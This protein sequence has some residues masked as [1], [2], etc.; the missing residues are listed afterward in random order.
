M[1]ARPPLPQGTAAIPLILP[2]LNALR[3]FEAAA[4]TGSHVAAA[5]ELGISAAAVSQHIRKLEDWLG[6]Q[7]FTRL[8]NRILLT[9]AGR[10]VFEGAAAGL[11]LI[12]DTAEA[13]RVR[14]SHARLVISC[15]E[16]VADKWLVPRLAAYAAAH[17]G[18]RFDLRIEPDPADFACHGIDLRLGYDPAHYPD[19][20]MALLVRDVV[21]PLCSPAY[22]DRNPAA[23]AQGMAAVPDEDLLHTDWGPAFGSHPGWRGWHDRAGLP[24]PVAARGFQI[25]NSAAALDLAR[26]GLG[27]VLGQRMVA[28]AD[29]AA[30]RLLAL[31]DL[32]LP[33]GRAYCLVWPQARRNRRHLAGLVD[34]LRQDAPP[35]A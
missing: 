3:A 4:R 23:G 19:K 33:L 1:L 32:S 11:Q 7:L 35:L 25:G 2:P 5:A 28:G 22:L 31:S 20:D 24:V 34:W 27:V 16:S 26:E 21:L 9:D 12:A 15:I 17:P 13:Q 30:G 18:F 10:E 6:K 29:L 14:P 8:N